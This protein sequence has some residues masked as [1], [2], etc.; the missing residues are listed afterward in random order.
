MLIS[1]LA[2]WEPE[3]HEQ[4][5]EQTVGGL[6]RWAAGQAPDQTALIEG[7]ADPAARRRWT[8]AELLAEAEQVARALAARFG[9]GERVAVWA[10]NIPEWVLLEFG[11]ALAGLTLVTVNPALRL[12]ELRHVLGDSRS[13]G[14]FLLREYRGVCLEDMLTAL[15]PELPGLREVVFFDEWKTFLTGGDTGAAGAPTARPGVGRGGP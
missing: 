13:A 6:L 1:G 15:R 2:Q 14:L 9:P 8:Y 4:V 11:A 10:S 3:D 5:G 7:V 12:S